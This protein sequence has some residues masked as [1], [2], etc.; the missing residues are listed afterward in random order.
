MDSKVSAN[1][2]RVKEYEKRLHQVRGHL[3]GSHKGNVPLQS[4]SVGGTGSGGAHNKAIGGGSKSS[5][6]TPGG[7]DIRN[8]P[9]KINGSPTGT[10]ENGIG[11]TKDGAVAKSGVGGTGKGPSDP[12][13]KPLTE[14]DYA[15]LLASN[16]APPIPGEQNKD[17]VSGGIPGGKGPK[18]AASQAGQAAYIAINL[19]FTFF[20]HVV[21]SGLRKVWT[22]IK[23]FILQAIE[24]PAFMFVGAGGIGGGGKGVRPSP[25]TATE[26]AV[27]G[28]SKK[29]PY[30]ANPAHDPGSPRFNSTKTPEPADAVSVFESAIEGNGHYYGRGA[31]DELYRFSS[32]NAGGVHFSGMT[33]E[34]GLRLED[35]P[36]GV[37]RSLGRVR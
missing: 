23:P 24:A 33:G 25:P 29:P 20:S 1:D 16:L 7:Q 26:A 8:Q 12:N 13:A 3:I 15:T 4:Y 10:G 27:S 34:S 14:L 30:R 5:T 28:A 19:F 22:A 11:V 31:N 36:I 6:S 18:P 21:E 9:G 35:I 32:D 37:R 17:G 2:P